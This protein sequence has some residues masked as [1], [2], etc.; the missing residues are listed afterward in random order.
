MECWGVRP[1]N[2][3]ASSVPLDGIVFSRLAGLSDSGGGVLISE[4]VSI[5]SELSRVV[6]L[7]GPSF[8][9][10]PLLGYREVLC[11]RAED[12]AGPLNISTT[13]PIINIHGSRFHNGSAFIEGS[14]SR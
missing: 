3:L 2:P 5:E 6:L 10:R 1:R 7:A 11:D 14:A 8:V 9:K 13:N 4:G 12:A